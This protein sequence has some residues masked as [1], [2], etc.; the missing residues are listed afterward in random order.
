MLIICSLSLFF[1]FYHQRFLDA[2]SKIVILDESQPV[3]DSTLTCQSL[4][5]NN[6]LGQ[7][8]SELNL[9]TTDIGTSSKSYT[10][11]IIHFI[12]LFN[13]KKFLLLLL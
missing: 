5:Y 2:S 11:F 13:R 1:L 6:S 10:L 4:L 7:G 3:S 8:F 12:Y 9:Q